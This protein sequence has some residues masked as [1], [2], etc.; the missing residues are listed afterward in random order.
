MDEPDEPDFDPDEAGPD[1][2]AGFESPELDDEVDEPELSEEPDD[3]LV[4]ESDDDSDDP[5]DP[6]EGALRDDDPRLS[7]L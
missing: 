5:V 2:G 4:D 6:E 7:V 3:V 1:D